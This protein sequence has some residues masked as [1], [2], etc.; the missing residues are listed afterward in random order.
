VNQIAGKE[1]DSLI[2]SLPVSEDEPR[3]IYIIDT[4]S[5]NEKN[6]CT[7]ANVEAIFS[8]NW[9]P[10]DYYHGEYHGSQPSAI[11]MPSIDTKQKVNTWGIDGRVIGNRRGLF[12]ENGKKLYFP[13]R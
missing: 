7:T 13:V 8:K 3:R 10:I 4:T 9:I 1:M 6:I 11:S 2:E 12:I 5:P